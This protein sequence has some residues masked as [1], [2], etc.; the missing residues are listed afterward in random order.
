MKSA[1]LA[2]LTFVYRFGDDPEVQHSSIQRKG[3][4]PQ[5]F[6]QEQG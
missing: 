4:D 2:T 5:L 3:Y 6:Y 1:R